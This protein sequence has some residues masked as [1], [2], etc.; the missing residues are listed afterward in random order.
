M[1]F[2]IRVESVQRQGN[3]GASGNGEIHAVPVA[4]GC[5]QRGDK[6]KRHW[7]RARL[8]KHKFVDRALVV[9]RKPQAIVGIGRHLADSRIAGENGDFRIGLGYM[10]RAAK[11]EANRLAI[12]MH[13]AFQSGVDQFNRSRRST[14]CDSGRA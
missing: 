7:K 4:L 10:G 14:V 11:L 13:I 6:I 1:K 8:G 5:D 2:E 12:G 3:N 9:C